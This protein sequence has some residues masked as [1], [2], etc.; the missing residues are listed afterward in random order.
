MEKVAHRVQF[1]S[2]ASILNEVCTGT[3]IEFNTFVACCE[4]LALRLSPAEI[5]VLFVCLLMKC[6]SIKS[7]TVDA[8]K[9]L[10]CPFKSV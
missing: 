1:V 6:E 5:D 7:I 4:S 2:A 10:V 9:E 8:L 3:D